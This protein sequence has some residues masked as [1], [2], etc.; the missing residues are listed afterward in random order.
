MQSNDMDNRVYGTCS[1]S[2]QNRSAD[3]AEHQQEVVEEYPYVSTGYRWLKV[4]SSLHIYM[5]ITI[6]SGIT[7]EVLVY[8]KASGQGNFKALR[9]TKNGNVPMQIFD[10]PLDKMI[11]S[12]EEYTL[13]ER[14]EKKLRE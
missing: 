8:L 3:C 13:T 9:A 11:S 4:S 6:G 5:S 1:Q 7:S 10:G 12:V 14:L 2:C